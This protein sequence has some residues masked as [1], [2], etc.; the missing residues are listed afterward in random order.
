MKNPITRLAAAAVVVV[1]LGLFIGLLTHTTTPA[2]A[3]D[4]TVEANQSLRSIHIKDFAP[5]HEDEPKEFWIA[6]DEAGGIE[7]VR[8]LC[9][10]GMLPRM[11]PSPSSGARAWPKSGSTRRTA[12]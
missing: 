2:Y 4:Q 6:C 9:P 10:P 12:S 3:L 8:Y 1:G 7:N 11:G 5:E